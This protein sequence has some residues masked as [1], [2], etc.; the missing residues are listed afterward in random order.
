M[1]IWIVRKHLMHRGGFDG[2]YRGTE[3]TIVSTHATRP[4]AAAAAKRKN[5]HP[6]TWRR[7]SVGKVTLK[8]TP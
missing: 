7:Y 6:N 8:E 4:E 5:D 1:T 2:N 3:F